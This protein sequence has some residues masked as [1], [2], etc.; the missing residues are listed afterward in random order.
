[1]KAAGEGVVHK[2]KF[3]DKPR[4]LEMLAKHFRL[5]GE[6]TDTVAVEELL[7][8]LDEGRARNAKRK[9]EQG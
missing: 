7:K 5:L 3:W 1:V 8:R 6:Q 4:A 2:I 9:K